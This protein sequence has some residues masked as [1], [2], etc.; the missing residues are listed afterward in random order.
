LYVSYVPVGVTEEQV[1]SQ[2]DGMEK[3]VR[4]FA[5]DCVMEQLGIIF[6]KH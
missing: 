4:L 3:Y 1:R 2:L 5:P 6:A